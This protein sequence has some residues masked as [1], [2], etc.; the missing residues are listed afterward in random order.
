MIYEISDQLG[1]LSIQ[2][3]GMGLNIEEI[4]VNAIENKLISEEEV[5]KLSDTENL[6]LILLPGFSSKNPVFDESGRG[7]GLDYVK[8]QM[9]N[10]GVA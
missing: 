5:R 7:A 9:T 8:T 3:E 2:D 6:E 1:S 10:F 4:V